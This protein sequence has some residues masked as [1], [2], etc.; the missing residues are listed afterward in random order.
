MRRLIAALAALA[1]LACAHVQASGP[2]SDTR[3]ADACVRSFRPTLHAWEASQ[4]RVP[5]GCAYLDMH[6]AVQVVSAADMPCK[7]TAHNELI[8]ACLHPQSRVI[9]LLAGRDDVQLTDS[10]V[11]EWVH[12]L[13]YCAAGGLDE[14]H[15]RAGLWALYG[16]NSVE[17]QAQAAAVIGPCSS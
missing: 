1:L 4:G 12:A 10:S 11:H 3:V 2:K 5:E 16:A 17:A 13:V 7:A 9:Y 8:V 6:Y 15:L 14:M